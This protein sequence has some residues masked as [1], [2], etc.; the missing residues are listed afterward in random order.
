[1]ETLS[2]GLWIDANVVDC[3]G[4]ILNYEDHFRKDGS[5]SRHFFRTGCITMSM[6]DET[7]STYE[8]KW[9]SFAAE[10]S[11]QFKDNVGGLAL[12]GIDLK[13]LFAH[14]LRLYGHERN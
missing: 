11:A 1:M 12:S 2:P 10:V 14:H 13:K 8:D 3:W 4:E 5:L 7:L 9:K 6:F